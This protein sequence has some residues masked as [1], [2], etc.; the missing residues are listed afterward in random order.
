GCVLRFFFFSSRRRH[1]RLVSDWSSDVCS[2]DLV[3][4][5]GACAADVQ[6]AA[7]GPTRGAPG[8]Y[9]TYTAS[10]TNAGPLAAQGVHVEL[11]PGSY[12]KSLT[13]ATTTMGTCTTKSWV[14]NC[15]IS[16]LAPG[17]S[18]SLT[19]TIRVTQA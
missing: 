6:V 5:W 14:A 18:A 1:T 9:L 17:S 8:D 16:S 11:R 15:T 2:S 19:M 7:T 12:G 4:M 3:G 10:V 13:G